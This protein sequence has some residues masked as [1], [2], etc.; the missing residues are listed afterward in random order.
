[1]D[2]RNLTEHSATA[3]ISCVFLFIG[4]TQIK[5]QCSSSYFSSKI[6][7][8]ILCVTRMCMTNKNV[9]DKEMALVY[10]VLAASPDNW[11]FRGCMYE[12]NRLLFGAEVLY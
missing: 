6:L 1:M 9:S 12:R 10:P 4:M 8:F 3:A 7:T 2:L 5:L 11:Y